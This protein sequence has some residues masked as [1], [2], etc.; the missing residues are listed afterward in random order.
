MALKIRFRQ[1][2]FMLIG[3]L[4][5]GGAIATEE[6]YSTFDASYAH[7]MSDGRVMRYGE[8]IGR[9]SDIE[10]IGERQA[11]IKSLSGLLSSAWN[12]PIR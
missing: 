4:E 1:Q 6:S 10:V 3:T 8:V 7:L 5:D 11:E 12:G 9:R 2:D